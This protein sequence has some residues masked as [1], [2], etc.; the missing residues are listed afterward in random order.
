M[1]IRRLAGVVQRRFNLNHLL[2]IHS[3]ITTLA[4]A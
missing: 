4:A 1:T 2:D 3:R